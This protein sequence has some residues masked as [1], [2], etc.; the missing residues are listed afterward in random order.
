[1]KRILGGIVLIFACIAGHGWA[2]TKYVHQGCTNGA[3]TYNPSNQQCTGGSATVYTTINN[4]LSNIVGGDTCQIEDGATY[5]EAILFGAIPSGSAGAPTRVQG[6]AGTL[7]SI[8]PTSTTQH[9]VTFRDG[10]QHIT[11]TNL[12]VDASAFSTSSTILAISIGY[13]SGVGAPVHDLVFEDLEIVGAPGYTCVSSYYA[14]N[15]ALH[16]NITFRRNKI[17]DCGAGVAQTNQHHGFYVAYF[18]RSVFEHNEL[19][20]LPNGYCIHQYNGASLRPAENVYRYNLCRDSARGILVWH[21][22]DTVLH[23]NVVRLSVANSTRGFDLRSGGANTKLYNNTIYIGVSGSA[24]CGYIETS[25]HTVRNTVC[26]GV[27]AASKAITLAPGVT[28]TFGGNFCSGGSTTGCVS[29]A[30]PQFVSVAGGDFNLAAG[31]P[32]IDAGV[33]D[34]TNPHVCV[35]AC[36]VGALEVPA[37]V[38]TMTTVNSTTVRWTWTVAHAPL[39][40][41][42]GMLSDYFEV[43]EN[44]AVRAVSACTPQ[45]ANAIDLTVATLSGGTTLDGSCKLRGCVRDSIKIG[46][47]TDSTGNATARTFTQQSITNT[48]GASEAT[49]TQTEAE[50]WTVGGGV[51][52][53]DFV[54]AK[55]ASGGTVALTTGPN[56]CVRAR[57]GVQATV[58][59][60]TV[61][62][63]WAPYRNINGGAYAALPETCVDGDVCYY[64]ARPSG[65]LQISNLAAT[66]QTITTGSFVAG[67]VLR[68][69]VIGGPLK[70]LLA[71]ESTEFDVAFCGQ[72]VTQQVCLRLR[73][74]GVA[75]NAH[76][77]TVCINP[78]KYSAITR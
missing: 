75:L 61:E 42:A 59:N 11:L 36:D 52:A 21:G 25:G 44:G 72:N 71:N 48:L 57:I 60:M 6:R 55:A 62:K 69:P 4:C 24:G 73:A 14:A 31:S 67:N 46:N 13:S 35:G 78:G 10:Q 54:L 7:P 19:W 74:D 26:W 17:R 34:S 41:A 15:S 64:D 29:A 77:E 76:T 53:P 37:A 18:E 20:N 58:N 66:V 63:V 40:C 47:K 65:G 38:P 16:H 22:T 39:V 28:G 2:A 3:T 49:L 1:M 12:K 32:A 51:N 9:V 68:A 50:I 30:D 43:R 33:T 8:R 45:G 56:F 23:D 70:R 27:D 5:A